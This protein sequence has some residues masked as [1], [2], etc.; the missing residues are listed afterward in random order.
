MTPSSDITRVVLTGGPCAGKT[1]ILARIKD[2][3]STLGYHVYIVPEAAT[4][5]IGTGF[6]PAS[7]PGDEIYEIQDAILEITLTLYR[8]TERLA[9]QLGK[10]PALIIYDRGSLDAK[11]YCTPNAWARILQS[12]NISELELSSRPYQGVIHL[13]TAAD[14]AREHY[15]VLNNAARLE[16]W[17]EAMAIDLR[18]REAWSEHPRFYLVDNSTSFEGKVRRTLELI[19]DILRSTR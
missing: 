2:H 8:Q 4:C 3:F 10:Y 18:L 15:S 1:T 6:I 14:G 7:F 17:E 13:V 9:R 11:A 12:R 5:V 16:S 19:H